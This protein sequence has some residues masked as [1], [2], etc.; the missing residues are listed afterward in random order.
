MA[1]RFYVVIELRD[2][3]T[4]EQI[5][6]SSCQVGDEVSKESVEAAAKIAAYLMMTY[7]I[8]LKDIKS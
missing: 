5:G 3:A 4:G 6:S 7:N 8:N 2:L 1:D